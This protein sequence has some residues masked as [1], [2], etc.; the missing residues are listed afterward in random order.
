MIESATVKL[1]LVQGDPASLR[2]AD[3]RRPRRGG[4]ER[5]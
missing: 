2:A 5:D 3:R 4:L 1:F